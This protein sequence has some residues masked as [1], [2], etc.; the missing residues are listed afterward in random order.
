MWPAT[1]HFGPTPDLAPNIMVERTFEQAVTLESIQA[2]EDASAQ[3]LKIRDVTFIK[4]YFSVDQ[5]RMLC[6]YKAPDAEAVR[7]AQDEALMPF[8]RVWSCQTLQPPHK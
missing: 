8:D 1:V 4:T 6:L 2:I 5:K 7:S 3:C